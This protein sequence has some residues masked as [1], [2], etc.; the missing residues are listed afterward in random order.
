MRKHHTRRNGSGLNALL[1]RLALR[2][3]KHESSAERRVRRAESDL[4]RLEAERAFRASR[5]GFHTEVGVVYAHLHKVE[6]SRGKTVAYYDVAF[7]RPGGARVSQRYLYG[8]NFR[9]KEVYQLKPLS[10]I[11]R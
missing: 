3:M 2:D 7:T 8:Y 1:A 5:P 10:R 4:I 9:T 6:Q 11:T